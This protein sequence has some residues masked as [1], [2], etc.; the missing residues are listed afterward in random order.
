MRQSFVSWLHCVWTFLSDEILIPK[1]FPLLMDTLL[2][3]VWLLCSN[4]N[5]PTSQTYLHQG[6][7]LLLHVE[8]ATL[9]VCRELKGS[10]DNQLSRASGMVCPLAHE[11]MGVTGF[12]IVSRTYTVMEEAGE[13]RTKVLGKVGRSGKSLYMP[14]EAMHAQPPKKDCNGWIVERGTHFYTAVAS[15]GL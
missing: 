9:N 7:S 13:T 5:I 2:V 3:Y 11:A 14:W 8:W 1:K 10:S 15:V 6:H 12:M 4:V